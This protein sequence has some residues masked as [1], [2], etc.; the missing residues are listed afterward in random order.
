MSLRHLLRII[1]LIALIILII[2]ITVQVRKVQSG[3]E[4]VGKR[5]VSMNWLMLTI[6][7]V[8]FGGSFLASNQ[9][10]HHRLSAKFS[11]K[12]DLKVS[13]SATKKKKSTK[14]SAAKIEFKEKVKLQDGSVK[15]T[16]KV[17]KGTKLV[18][19]SFDGQVIDSMD[20]TKGKK[21]AKFKSV[22][23]TAGKYQVIGIHGKRQTK[24]SLVVAA[25]KTAS[26]VNSPAGGSTGQQATNNATSGQGSTNA[27]NGYHYEYRQII[28]PDEQPQAPEQPQSQAQNSQE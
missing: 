5:Y 24:K 21:T 28:V 23:T 4:H 25:E 14:Q 9:P 12:S 15:V 8:A 1:S 2:Q 13:H 3:E 18:I 7:L 26:S 27:N 6:V 17:P 22:F 16:F 20:N 19:K 11:Q 10:S